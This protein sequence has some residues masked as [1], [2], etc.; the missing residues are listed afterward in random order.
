MFEQAV[1][2]AID[3]CS[4]PSVVNS[5]VCLDCSEIVAGVWQDGVAHECEFCDGKRV[6]NTF[7][8]VH[9]H[10]DGNLSGL[11]KENQKKDNQ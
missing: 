5:G 3:A 9:A 6:F 4:D 2:V 8:A 1:D 11:V 7:T 10:I